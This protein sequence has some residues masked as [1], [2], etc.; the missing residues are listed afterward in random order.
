MCYD[1]LVIQCTKL[2]AAAK[3]SGN[4]VEVDVKVP[5]APVI[6]GESS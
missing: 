5:V 1:E 3:R 2:F 6:T 4:S